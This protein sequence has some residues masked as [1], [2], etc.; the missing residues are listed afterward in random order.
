[1]VLVLL[2]LLLVGVSYFTWGCC[3]ETFPEGVSEGE[4]VEDPLKL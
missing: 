4:V 2:G 1:M 3:M